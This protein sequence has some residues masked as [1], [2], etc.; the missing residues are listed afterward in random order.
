MVRKQPSSRQ[1]SNSF[2]SGNGGARFEARVQASFVVL[3]LSGGCAPCLGNSL[4]KKI[5]LQGKVNGFETDDFI[6]FAEDGVSG[7]AR[8]LLGQVKRRIA[9]SRGNG[10]FE[11]SLAA[12]WRD[13]QNPNAFDCN[14]DVLAIMTGQLNAID[15][16]TLLWLS[17]QA[18]KGDNA[19]EFFARVHQSRFSPPKTARK[20]S[21]ISEI[22]Q[23]HSEGRAPSRDEI[24]DFLSVLQVLSY[25]LDGEFG[26]VLPLLY[27]HISQFNRACPHWIWPRIV[28]FVET[29]DQDAGTIDW[30]HLPSDLKE[31]FQVRRVVSISPIEEERPIATRWNTHPRAS[32]LAIASL[33]GT[34]NE[35]NFA[36]SEVVAEALNVNYA[37]WSEEARQIVLMPDT[38]LSIHGTTWRVRTPERLWPQLAACLFD[39]DVERFCRIAQRVLLTSVSFDDVA[40]SDAY[41]H[42]GHQ[43]R[44]RYSLEMRSRI[45]DGLALLGSNPALCRRCSADQIYNSCFLLVEAVLGKEDWVRWAQ[46]NDVLPRL[47][48]SS[49]AAFLAAIEAAISQKNCP[50]EPLFA[51]EKA[52]VYGRNYLTGLLWGLEILA[53]DELHLVRVCV[54]LAELAGRDPGGQSLNRPAQSLVSILLPWCPRTLASATKQK[55]AVQTVLA[56]QPNVGWKMLLQ[57][58]PGGQSTSRGSTTP[59]YRHHEAKCRENTVSMDEYKEMV[60]AYTNMAVEVASLNYHRLADLIGRFTHLPSTCTDALLQR[61]EA[62]AASMPEAGKALI[63]QALNDLLAKR[64]NTDV[65]ENDPLN[66]AMASLCSIAATYTPVNLVAR[67]QYLFDRDIF[68]LADLRGDVE[69]GIHKVVEERNAAVAEILAAH[70]IAGVLKLADGATYTED[71]GQS[72]AT[73]GDPAIDTELLP[74]FLESDGGWQRTLLE[75]FILQRIRRNTSKWLDQLPIE[76]WST[77]QKVELLKKLPFTDFAWNRA[78]AWLGVHEEEYWKAAVVN[79]WH[80]EK[81]FTVA[82]GKLADVGRPLAA[83]PCLGVMVRGSQKPSPSQCIDILHKAR[84]SDEKAGKRDPLDF[85]EIITFLQELPTVSESVL[86]ELEWAYI[87]YLIRDNRAAPKTLE[88]RLAKDP[89]Y[90]CEVLG[91]AY[92]AANEN[93]TGDRETAEDRDR[94]SIASRVLHCWTIVPGTTASDGSFNGCEFKRWFQRAMEI[95]AA[96]GHRS[97]AMSII[98]RLLTYAPPAPDGLFIAR[99][100]AAILNEPSNEELRISYRTQ[101]YNSRG[102]HRVDPTG[103]AE[104]QLAQLHRRNA[105]SV[106]DQGFHRF[107]TALRELASTYDREADRVISEYASE[108]TA[109][110]G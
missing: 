37:N 4:I 102:I 47:A 30:E 106:E 103:A 60:L 20:L 57:L 85:A 56:E 22:I 81:D 110:L 74:A 98:G 92:R 29:W 105:E 55:V 23:K 18:R 45:A 1:L 53:W 9:V 90:F 71:I 107:A 5:K 100:I 78:A 95:S 21:V 58:L 36:D 16:S 80:G 63:W 91:Y 82:V 104:R 66:N 35:R 79:P 43:G 94:A 86:A 49:P 89:S 50:F 73:V 87:D 12:A 93:A 27:S 64:C 8:R 26:V 39:S 48:E 25:D 88:H 76:T 52:G 54:L 31:V 14:R 83:I 2:S 84:H 41:V 108:E 46:M 6:V 15:A 40:I 96:T 11:S 32:Q 109:N 62:V 17:A 101:L 13:F 7:R 44:H 67:H 97:I 72:L 59:R 69:A 3:M 51:L 77:R 68:S 33:I 61:L 34:W 10:A 42:V 28:E 70:G 65:P 38:P 75:G 99:D 19:D 24:R